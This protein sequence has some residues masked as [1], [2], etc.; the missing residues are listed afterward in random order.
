MGILP[1]LVINIGNMPITG[2]VL[3]VLINMGAAE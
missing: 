3:P 2:M 1:V